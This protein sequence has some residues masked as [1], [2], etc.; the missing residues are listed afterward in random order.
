VEVGGKHFSAR[1]SGWGTEVLWSPDSRA[2]AANQ[3]EGGGGIGHRTYV[4]YLTDNGLRKVD[5]SAPV[6]KVFGSPVKCE[7]P[8]SPNTATLKWLDSKRILVVA[9]VVPVSICECGGTFQTYELSLPYIEIV[10]V[11]TQAETRRFFGGALGCELR[12]ADD[13]CARSWQT[14]PQTGISQAYPARDLH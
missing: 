10:Q 4:F 14:A 7:A 13:R 12:R 3:T 5:V 1:L 9:E 2:F 6:E 11:Y 8:V